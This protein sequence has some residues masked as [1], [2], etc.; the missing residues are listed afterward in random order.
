[1]RFSVRV[2][3]RP[4]EDERVAD[5]SVGGGLVNTSKGQVRGS[6]RDP[7]VVPR[8]ANIYDELPTA[9][10]GPGD[11][12]MHGIQR[13]AILKLIGANGAQLLRIEE[14]GRCGKEWV[15]YRYFVRM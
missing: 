7:L 14:D 9:T 1:M 8:L 5:K 15:G 4:D 3:E 12:P 10:E 11:F 2:R 13:E 6:V